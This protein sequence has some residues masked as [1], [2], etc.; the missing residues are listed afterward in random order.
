M[1]LKMKSFKRP[2]NARKKLEV[3]VEAAVPCNMGTRQRAWKLRDIVASEKTCLR[4]KTKPALWK[5]MNPQRRRLESALPTNHEEHIVEKGFNSLTHYGLVHKFIPMP[6]AM[7]IPDATAAANK[8][9]EKLAKIPA[10]NLEKMKSEKDVILEAQKEK[11]KST[12]LH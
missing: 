11:G 10:W 3:P 4:K 2:S 6:Q 5:L 7:K 12:L 9:W 1:I 8:E